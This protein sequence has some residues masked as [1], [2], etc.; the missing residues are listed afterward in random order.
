MKVMVLI[1][2]ELTA[3]HQTRETGR[4]TCHLP[5][6][7]GLE[8]EARWQNARILYLLEEIMPKLSLL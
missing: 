6:A 8:T 4:L 1:S 3:Y 5:L 2:Q 7:D